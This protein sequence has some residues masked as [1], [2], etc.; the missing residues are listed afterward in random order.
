MEDAVT[1]AARALNP[2]LS[3]FESLGGQAL[4]AVWEKKSITI[5]W[6]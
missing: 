2:Q 1:L 5:L 4:K 3:L 6:K